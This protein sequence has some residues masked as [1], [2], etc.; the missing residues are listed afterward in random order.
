MAGASCQVSF[1]SFHRVCFIHSMFK[2]EGHIGRGNQGIGCTSSRRRDHVYLVRA[3]RSLSC[4]VS[5]EPFPYTDLEAQ[6]IYF[7]FLTCP[8][9]IFFLFSF[10]FLFLDLKEESAPQHE[11]ESYLIMNTSVAG[12]GSL[13]ILM[14]LRDITWCL[15]SS[16]Y[17]TTTC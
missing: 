16:S 6:C 3:S 13:L 1:L 10:F 8:S 17:S 11:N 9:C 15:T 7:C 12:S 2:K 14:S 5:T 4:E